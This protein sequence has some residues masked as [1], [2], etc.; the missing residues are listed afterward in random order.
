MQRISEVIAE[1]LQSAGVA[2]QH[3]IGVLL[4]PSHAEEVALELPTAIVLSGQEGYSW[5]A[6]QEHISG[7]AF[8][9]YTNDDLIG[10]EIASGFKN[11]IALAVGMA[12]GM[13]AGDNTRGTLMTR[14]IAELARMGCAAGRPQGDLLRPGRHRR[15]DHHLHQPATAAIATSVR[16]SPARA[17]TRNT[18]WA[19]ASRWSRACS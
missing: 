8:R 17:T 15:H 13:G 19:T 7:P 1:E 16:P 12:D 4:G 10:V 2:D 11:I 9:V 5:D 6:L 3:P 18:C 14:G